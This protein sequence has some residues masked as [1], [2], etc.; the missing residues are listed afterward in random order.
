M[1]RIFQPL[2]FMLARCTRNQLIRQVEFLKVENQM[3]RMRVPRQKIILKPEERTRLIRL[4]QAIGPAMRHLITIVDYT[5]YRTWIRRLQGKQPRKQM[6]RPRTPEVIRE[7]VLKLARENHWGYTRILGELRKLGYRK[8]SR[9]TVVNILKQAGFDPDS[10]RGPGSWDELLK[11]H[12]ETLWQ[13]D[14]FSKRILSR[15]GVPQV[16]ALVF[17][18]VATRRVWVSPCAQKPTGAWVKKQVDAFLEHAAREGLPVTLVSRDRDKLY[19]NNFD[20]IMGVHGVDINMLAY[21]SPNLN[22]Y[23]ERFV[24]SI[25]QECLD[26]FLIFGERHFDYLVREYVEHYH[27]ERPHQGLENQLIAGQP[28]PAPPDTD[29]EVRCRTRLGGLLRHYYRA[30][31]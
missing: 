15:L 3:L 12:A 1:A 25:Q 31:A 13:C 11:M 6:G 24:Q 29:G 30:A 7:L 19:R 26:H 5:T 8:I 17:L 2:L 22:A 16:F 20:H 14:F 27:Q 9:Q 10:R 28:P 23:V 21:R 4:G 18:N